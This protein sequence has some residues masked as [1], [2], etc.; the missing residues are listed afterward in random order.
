MIQWD[1]IRTGY[2]ALYKGTLPQY[3]A[4]VKK[5]RDCHTVT[6]SVYVTPFDLGP[7]QPVFEC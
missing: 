7:C 2:W 3:Q 1:K 4:N 6:G 5:K